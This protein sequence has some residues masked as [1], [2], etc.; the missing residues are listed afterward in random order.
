MVTTQDKDGKPV[1]LTKQQDI[2][3]AILKNNKMKFLQSS[4]TPF[5]CSPLKEEFGFKGLTMVAQA[6]LAGVYES[7][8]SLDER[9]IQV[10]K[11]WQIPEEVRKLG[12]QQLS[13]TLHD[14]RRF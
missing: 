5:Y 12:P 11:Q 3:L 6:T 1:Y 7:N 8:H 10:I 4:Q 14:Y 13:L 9:T 2:E